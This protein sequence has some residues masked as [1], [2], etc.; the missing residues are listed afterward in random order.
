LKALRTLK[1][2]FPNIFSGNPGKLA[3]LA[4][5]SHVEKKQKKAELPKPAQ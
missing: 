4:S 3:D 1:L 5:A 2:I